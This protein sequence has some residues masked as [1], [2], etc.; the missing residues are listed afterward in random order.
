MHLLEAIT[1]D[2]H[3]PEMVIVKRS[4]MDLYFQR[5]IP[6]HLWRSSR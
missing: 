4:T 3:H 2:I 1:Y 5:H 6:E